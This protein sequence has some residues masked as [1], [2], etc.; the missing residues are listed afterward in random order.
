MKLLDDERGVSIVLG[1]VLIFAILLLLLG[2]LQANAVPQLN[3]E[4]EFDHNEEV[5]QDMIGVRD[6]YVTA[7]RE[8]S[9][10]SAS[11]KLGTTY[12]TRFVLLNP[13]PASGTIRTSEPQQVHIDGA[14]LTDICGRTPTDRSLVYQPNYNEYES[15]PTVRQERA[16]TYRAFPNGEVRIDASQVL[17]RGNTVT[18]MPLASNYSRSGSG[19]ASV[20]FSGTTAGKREVTGSLNV[21]FPTELSA[22]EWENNDQLFGDTAAVTNVVDNGTGTV[23]AVLQSDTYQVQCLSVGIDEPPSGSPATPTPTNTTPAGASINPAGGDNVILT[24]VSKS[25]KDTVIMTLRNNG[26]DG[27]QM[28]RARIPFYDVGTNTGGGGGLSGEG[29][30]ESTVTLKIGDEWKDV[31]A[32][33][34]NISAGSSVDVRVTFSGVSGSGIGGDFFIFRAEYDNAPLATYYVAIPGGN[35]S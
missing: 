11:V 20:T 32:A 29:E 22:S 13:P 8:G 3:E 35:S 14:N 10:S 30:L 26:T 27:V 16:V 25:G 31:R 24:N 18:V 4:I 12:P 9:V 6:A 21:T 23:T 34:V 28:T 17:V 19:T 15:A 5:T 33:N 1:A 2:I 7:A